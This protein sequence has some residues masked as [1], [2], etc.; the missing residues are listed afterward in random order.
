MNML[1]PSAFAAAIVNHIWQSTLCLG[2]AALVNWLVGRERPAIRH[3]VWLLASV[4]FLIP[5]SVLVLL[6]T[7]IRPATPLPPVSAL[8]ATVLRIGQPFGSSAPRK[9]P[10]AEEPTSLSWSVALAAVWVA[11]AATTAVARWRRWRGLWAIVQAS[12]FVTDGRE[13]DALVAACARQPAVRPV[14]LQRFAQAIDPAVLGVWRPVV[15]WPAPLTARL[16]NAQ[17]AAIL[18]HELA[19]IRRR[20]NLAAAFHAAVETIYWW[21]PGLR[22]LG[23]RLL[24]DRE[25]ACDEA[26]LQRGADRASY[27][28]SL[29][30]VCRLC[31]RSSSPWLAGI[32]GPSLS[33]RVEAVMRFRRTRALGWWMFSGLVLLGVALVAGPVVAGAFGVGRPVASATEPQ[34]SIAGA[35]PVPFGYRGTPE[36]LTVSMDHVSIGGSGFS[37]D[38]TNLGDA[39]VTAVGF[40]AILERL[41]STL[42]A[43]I[44]TTPLQRVS[45]RRGESVHL[46]LPWLSA[47]ELVQL[48]AGVPQRVQPFLTIDRIEYADGTRWSQTLHPQGTTHMAVLG[49]ATPTL[50]RSLVRP[51]DSPTAATWVCADASD[52]PYSPGAI[53]AIRDESG[54]RARCLDGRWIEVDGRGTPLR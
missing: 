28:E 8:P 43:P 34:G 35:P 1:I 7:A 5:F 52:R 3:W 9:A 54:R 4:K 39:T 10:Q 27:A 30:I 45:L 24:I 32:L 41:G 40:A 31:L 44:S 29:L 16:S 38:V 25:R 51:A 47:T 12:P 14:S 48:Q 26:V 46:A 22:W 2:L 53:I 13:Y 42:S 17:F 11:G 36:A 21:H 18:D 6:G 20:D 15:L 23:N 33:H 37:A 49:L 50:P 19:H